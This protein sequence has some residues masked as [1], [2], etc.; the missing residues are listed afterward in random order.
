MLEEP[1]LLVFRILVFASLFVYFGFD[2]LE[3]R[4][5]KDE[6]EELIR[7]KS[8]ELV[9]KTTTVALSAMVVFIALWP[10][11]PALIPIVCLILA[12][13]YVEI[14]GKIYFRKKY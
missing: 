13:M 2:A 4:R 11:T 6:R 12:T 7:L 14:S 9:H 3:R 1:W 5:I 10:H 8:L